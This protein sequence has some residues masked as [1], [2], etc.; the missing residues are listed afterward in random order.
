[1]IPTCRCGCVPDLLAGARARPAVGPHVPRQGRRAP[2]AAPRGR[3]AAPHQPTTAFG[4]GRPGDLRRARAAVAPSAALPSPGHPGHDPALASPPRP[5]TMDL[6][7]PGRTAT[8]RRCP[9]RSGAADGAGEPALGIPADPGR[10]AQT[11]P[12]RRRLD[13]P[14]DPASA[15]ASHRHRSG[16][17]TPAGGSSCAPRPPA[18]SRSTSSTSTAR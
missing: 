13:D 9:R 7:P 6:P 17:P 11:R 4:L 1:M 14:P 2:R 15:T 10:A 16:T 8:D 3:R 5:P 12:P 18:C